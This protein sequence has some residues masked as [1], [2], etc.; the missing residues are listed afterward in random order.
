MTLEG[1]SRILDVPIASLISHEDQV[2][3]LTDMYSSAHK[4][5]IANNHI[6]VLGS[7]PAGVPLEEVEDVI[8]WEDIPEDWTRGG[9]RYFAL[10]VHGSSMYP[11]Y[12]DGDVIILIKQETCENGQDCAVMVGNTEATFKRVKF[13]DDGIILQSINP[14]YDSY[15]YSNTQVQELPVVILGVVVELRRK[16]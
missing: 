7:I 10:K 13:T 4:R 14:D 16:I 5:G 3:A 8:D 15:V 6:P 2:S 12:E 11:R 1:I 9:R